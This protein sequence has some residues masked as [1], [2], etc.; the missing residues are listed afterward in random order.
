MEFAFG[1]P[2]YLRCAVCGQAMK[3]ECHTDASKF[4][5]W[6]CNHRCAENDIEYLTDS[7]KYAL[8]KLEGE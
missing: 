2:S 1:V 8:T 6:C 4:R 3:G 5:I 7:P